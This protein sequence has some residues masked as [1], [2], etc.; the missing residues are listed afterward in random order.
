MSRCKYDDEHHHDGDQLFDEHPQNYHA[1]VYYGY[2]GYYHDDYFHYHRDHARQRKY[3][4]WMM[5]IQVPFIDDYCFSRNYGLQLN[6][7]S[8]A[9]E[10]GHKVPQRAHGEFLQQHSVIIRI[11]KLNDIMNKRYLRD[12]SKKMFKIMS[13]NNMIIRRDDPKCRQR[14]TQNQKRK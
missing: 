13:Q 5:N 7:P 10:N 8:E 9:S 12:S 4:C 3:Y 11:N 1:L 14:R 6:Y 2:Y